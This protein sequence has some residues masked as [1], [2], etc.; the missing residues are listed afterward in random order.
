MRLVIL[1]LS[2]LAFLM[3]QAT[4][5]FS[6]LPDP[7]SGYDL[8]RIYSAGQN[9]WLSGFLET[10]DTSTNKRLLA[11]ISGSSYLELGSRGGATS[12]RRTLWKNEVLW[13]DFHSMGSSLYMNSQLGIG[14]D[15]VQKVQSYV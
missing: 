9:V 12:P 7:P 8:D 11:K 4:I 3:G 2:S 14:M 13:F 6:S 1:F 5:Q 10:G 15:S